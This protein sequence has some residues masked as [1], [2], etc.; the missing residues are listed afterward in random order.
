M[1]TNLLEI[2]G[3][4]RSLVDQLAHD[5][6]VRATAGNRTRHAALIHGLIV[7]I[8]NIASRDLPIPEEI[9]ALERARERAVKIKKK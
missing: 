4:L 7:Q 8:E 1:Q 6:E 9:Y 5:A 3:Q 2:A